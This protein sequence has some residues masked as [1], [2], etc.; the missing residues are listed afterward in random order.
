MK[1]TWAFEN[2]AMQVVEGPNNA[3]ISSF[4]NDRAGGLVR[5]LLQNSIDARLPGAKPV[6][7]TFTIVKFP[8]D[9]FD[10][11]GLYKAL[12][13]SFKSP[14]N[15]DRYRKQFSRGLKMLNSAKKKGMLDVLVVTDR[16]TTGASDENGRT[17]KWW[18]L[19]MTVGKSEKDSK[20][21]GGSFGIGKHAAF[22][23][24]D[25]RSVLYATAYRDG[26]NG[27]LERRFRG[28]AIL[29][30]HE[31][32]NKHFKSIGYLVSGA[33]G[34]RNYYVPESLSLN[35]PGV[36]IAILGFPTSPGKLRS[37][38]REA[39]ESLVVNFFHALVHKNLVVHLLGQTI[40]HESL[41][42]IV[43][44]M[45]EE[46]EEKRDL[47]A[48]S[49][50]EIVSHTDIDG[51]GRV[52]LRI[53]V[54]KDNRNQGKTLA[55]VR[56]S[57][58]K[59]TDQLG[60]M[61]LSPSQPMIRFPRSWYGFTAIVECLSKGER[62]LLREAEGP[63]HDGISPDNADD[64]ERDIVRNCLRELGSW[65]KSE[66]ESLAKPPEP[67]R[68]DNASE[69]ASFLP[70]PGDGDTSSLLQGPDSI[71]V[72]EPT[73]SPILPVGLGI[74]GG[75]RRDGRDA[76]PTDEGNEVGR[77]RGNKQRNKKSR[78]SRRQDVNV[79]FH[80]VRRLTSSLAQWPD[81]TVQF[82]FDMPPELPKR[83]R[84]YAVGEDGKAEQLQL[85]RAY[86]GGR[87]IK[88]SKGEIVGMDANQMAGR[89]VQIDMKAIRPI[90][91]RRLEI[92]ST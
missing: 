46:R 45:S 20:D 89:R 2:N 41:D 47:V 84:L 19:T 34:K 44:R 70:L 10:I 1:Y 75:G 77:H 82:A 53:R 63:R 91:N 85:E 48:V 55:L 8:V 79:A 33:Q 13:A 58:M 16:N 88:V 22:A 30:S 66:I 42:T 23:A 39:L 11:D 14:D 31:Q 86:F 76:V 64:A 87:K 67:A 12:D 32:G 18:S 56:D 65:V 50:S 61:R 80:D 24:T 74:R 36:A 35:A 17:D 60:N 40:D 9:D 6:E 15:D 7:V 3:G 90:G 54:D 25:I 28:K 69:M 5:E 59:I 52:N 72:S 71:E 4:T 62:S 43:G 29:V 51:I 38:K 83:I 68:T 57:G 27:R 81:H 78:K 92:R 26:N 37:W 73:L 49:K 21:S